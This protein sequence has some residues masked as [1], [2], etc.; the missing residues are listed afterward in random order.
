MGV[1]RA[2]AGGAQ[3]SRTDGS[4][5]EG[6]LGAAVA[7]RLTPASKPPAPPTGR[8][9]LDEDSDRGTEQIFYQRVP[10]NPVEQGFWGN[11]LSVVDA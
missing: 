1:R 9:S 4:Y 10:Q 11:G 8:G 6:R 3:G 2:S 7:T 5:G